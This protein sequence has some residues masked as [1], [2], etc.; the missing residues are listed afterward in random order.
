MK[1][2]EMSSDEVL[3]KLNVS[4][5][6]GLCGFEPKKRLMNYGKNILSET[7]QNSFLKKIVKQLSDFMTMTLIFAS[8]ISLAVSYIQKSKEY[9]DALIILFI[10]ILNVVIGILQE[11]KAEKAIESLKHLS[12]P[13]AKVIR[14]GRGQKINSDE[15]VPG[16]ILVLKT[17]D[18]ICA[19]ARII[20]SSGFFVEESAM[21]GESFSVSKNESVLDSKVTTIADKKNMV[22]SGSIVTRG[23]AKAV[24]TKTGMNTEVGKIAKIIN[25][26]QEFR[27]PLSKR[28]ESTGKIIGIFII[29][30]CILVFILGLIQKIDFVEMFMISISLAV[31]A[32]PEGLPAVVTV[33][34]ASGVKRMA[35]RNTIVRNLS[36]VETLGHTA[37]ICSDKTGT[38]TMNKMVVKEIKTLNGNISNEKF[39]REILTLGTLCNNSIISNNGLESSIRG[40]PTENALLSAAVKIGISKLKLEN[41]LKRVYEI[42]FNSTRKLMTTVHVTDDRNYKVVTKGALD[43]VLKKCTKYKTEDGIFNLDESLKRKIGNINREMSSKSLRVIA[44]A[45][46]DISKL[47]KDDSKLEDSLIFCG[48][49]GIEDPIRPEVKIAVKECK[50]AG[51][52]PVMITGDH[53]HTAEA[54]A[55]SLGILEG[56]LKVMTGAEL[57]NLT[58]EELAKHIHS[59]SVFARVSPEHKVK[60]V[61]AFQ[62]TGAVVAMTGDG[63][64]DAPALKV[65]DIGCAMGK[66][67]TDAAKSAADMVITDDNFATIV[68]AVRQGRGMFE[69]IKKTIHF[70]LS[71][72]IGEVMVVFF[73]FLIGVPTPLLAV[74]LLWINLVTDAFPALALGVDPIDIEIMK[75][76]PSD[77]KKGL[78]SA[79]RIY[80][81]IIEGCFIAAIGFLSYT[82]GRVFFDINPMNPVIGRTMAF[83]TLGL[84]QVMHVFNVQSQKSLFV[85]GMLSN[86]KLVYSAILCIILEVISITIPSLNNFFKTQPLNFM[87]WLI[88]GILSISPILVSELEKLFWS[89]KE[90]KSK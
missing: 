7:K 15:V 61:K 80:N 64:N 69:N 22:F 68:E 47:T 35:T 84:S 33:V 41:D 52:K 90:K 32:I 28:L 73:A 39:K 37:V 63:V 26:D 12:S 36:A 89:K 21:T 29:L 60:I 82:L 65:A 54:I 8:G 9:I 59:Y 76:P 48:I 13:Q 62:S 46:K 88:V 30:I 57:N 87:Q 67:G 42:A 27:T 6:R 55:H 66:S 40:E 20:E 2:H 24:V 49:V 81:I 74:H 19:D 75:F 23:H 85:T 44:I 10:V 78:F 3:K 71:T 86:L 45:Y 34:L 4:S 70:L 79:S 53:V 72:N 56:N 11:S 31:A 51:I 18:L 50:K 83:A 5:K 14:D 16:D 17:G 58:D 77:S 43:V 1:W 25:E 38:L